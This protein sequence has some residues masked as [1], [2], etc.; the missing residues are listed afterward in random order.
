MSLIQQYLEITADAAAAVK[1]PPNIQRDLDRAVNRAI[2]LSGKLYRFHHDFE[3]YCDIDLTK[4]GSD[5]Y[6][7]HPSCEPLMLAYALTDSPVLQWVPA[8]GEEM[9]SDLVEIMADPNAVKFAW[10]KPFE[11]GIWAN[12]LGMKTDHEGWR[13]PMVLAFSLSLPGKLEKCG[14]V[15]DLPEDLQKMKRG[16]LLIKKFCTPR[17][18]TKTKPNTRNFPED[19]PADW[20]EFKLYNRTDVEA[21][22]GVYKR[23]R[24]FDMPQE[25]WDLWVLDQKINQAGIPINMRY[26]RN[27]I[28]VFTDLVKSRLDRMREL[29]G[30]D[31]P[32][33]TEQLL[34]WLQEFG[35]PFDDLKKG[36]VERGRDKLKAQLDANEF[37][38][39]ERAEM[40]IVLEVLE[41]RLDT[42]KSSPKKY[43]ALNRAS[44]KQGNTG[45]LRNAFQYA[46]AGRTWRWAGRLFQA[47]NL[48][49]PAT[50]FLEKNIHMVA[51]HLEFID[52]RGLELIYDKPMDVL[53]S[54]I[55][56]AAQAPE[57]Y[58]FIDA[59]LN[60]IENRVL[61]WESSCAKI[62]RVFELNRD[63][64]IDFATYLFGGQYNALW[65][66][67]KG[68]DSKKR[69]I[70]K[71]GVL[72]CGYMLGAGERKV[73]R[74][75]GEVEG[76]GLLGYAWNMGIKEFTEDQS[77][78]SVETFRREFHEVK[79]F[80][81]DFEKAMKKCIRTGRPTEINMIRFDM[82]PPFLRM[83]LPSGHALHYC[84]P[85][86]EEI[87]AP[88]G[89]LKPTITYES[90]NDKNQW[91][92]TPTHPGKITENATQAI[93]RDLLG[94]GMLL[95]DAEGIDIRIHVHDQIVALAP[96]D[97]AE[98]QLKLL[99]ECMQVQPKWAKGLPLG[100]AG[101]ISK[102]FVKD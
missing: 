21:E 20:E 2:Q 99:L 9:P 16:K 31:N 81:Y 83:I 1:L 6:S 92:R 71:P 102:I 46:G 29:T 28:E 61:G 87:K 36:H 53:T 58:V 48:P 57:G 54:G 42:S 14:P 33:S 56:P 89:E 72:G 77:K 79:Q 88:W 43:A 5:V 64:Y 78:L 23:I 60:A 10:N 84:R 55:R 12:A 13:D 35:Y 66:E 11:W 24:H 93:A 41:L 100:C 86:I 97:K 18:P 73:N 68:G 91:V 15:V 40:E 85:R 70:S 51:R 50:K 69:T 101:F 19:F 39:D 38:L 34:P 7:R 76:T 37:G 82:K 17:K 27:A 63:P 52:A 8:E 47:Q 30:L 80:W 59:D 90:L 22:R 45:V 49:R 32:N 65:D 62:L 94:H 4:V 74:Q 96:E 44:H 67:Y 25:E 3:T 95:A 98:A 26:V 75:T